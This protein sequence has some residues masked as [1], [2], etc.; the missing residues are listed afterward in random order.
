MMYCLLPESNLFKL[1]IVSCV[2]KTEGA[3]AAVAA[4][5]KAFVA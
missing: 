1:R 4:F 3:A 5:N 2:E